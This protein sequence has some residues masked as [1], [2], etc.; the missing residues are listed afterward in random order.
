[1]VKEPCY[2][3]KGSRQ[4]TV[5][6]QTFKDPYLGLIFDHLNDEPEPRAIVV[7]M[8]CG[9]VSH[10]PTLTLQEIRILYKRYRDV[11]FRSETGD[12]YFDRITSLPK[13]QSLNY[14]KVQKLNPIL[15]RVLPKRPVRTIYDVGAGGG[16]FLKTF[17]DN[18]WGSWE[19]YGVEATRAYAELAARRLSIPVANA[20]YRPG[21]FGMRFDFI[22]VIKVLE[23]ARDPI[24]LLKGIRRDLGNEGLVYIEVPSFREI[25][26]LPVDHDQLT[27]THLYF[28]SEPVL[29][30]LCEQASFEVISLE[31]VPQPA[32]D[33]DLVAFLRKSKGRRRKPLMLPLQDY[34]EVLTLTQR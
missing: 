9:F 19:A 34:R 27:Y 1:V 8:D 6:E 30:Y 4:E 29:R 11:S 10:F 15:D 17:L 7:C 24:K 13:D 21:L 23:H 3:C 5:V 18:A 14:Q 32:G 20:M 28:Y 25:R 26:T 16:V 12:Q 22:T 31:E 33:W 2:I